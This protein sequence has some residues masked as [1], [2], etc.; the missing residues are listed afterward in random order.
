MLP[1]PS[2]PPG[3]FKEINSIISKFIWNDK[4]PDIKL[5]THYNILIAQEDWLYQILN[6]IIGRSSLSP[7]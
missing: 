7:S 3:Y 1:L 5:T 6:Y 2:P 4:C